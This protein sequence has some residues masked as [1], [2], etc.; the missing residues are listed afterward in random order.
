MR[1]L[2]FAVPLATL[3]AGIITAC[4]SAPEVSVWQDGIE[5]AARSGSIGGAGTA[6]TLPVTFDIAPSWTPRPVVGTAGSLPRQGD[7]TLACEVDAK[8]A[9]VFGFLRV[10]S[11]TGTAKNSRSALDAYLAEEKKISG[12]EYRETKAGPF[13]ATEVTYLKSSADGPAKRERALSVLLPEGYVIIHVGGLD[14]QEHEKLLPGY[15]LARDT[16]AASSTSFPR[17]Q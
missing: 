12:P 3:L 6:C 5:P 10:W 2:C 9:G 4:S 11:G 14:T 17:A 8:P 7:A 1:R 15:E 13:S 16:M